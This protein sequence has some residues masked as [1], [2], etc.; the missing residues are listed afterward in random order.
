M[1]NSV[2]TTRRREA[3]VPPIAHRRDGIVR[4][5]EWI[6]RTEKD[7]NTCSSDGG[8]GEIE[9]LWGVAETLEIESLID[10]LLIKLRKQPRI[11]GDGRERLALV[12]PAR[13]D[14]GEAAVLGFKTMHRQHNLPLMIE[15]LRPSGRFPSRLHRRKD[16][17]EKKADDS[18][19][20]QNFHKREAASV[21][22]EKNAPTWDDV[23]T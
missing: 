10:R 3:E 13:A 1:D 14:V 8:V 17:S 16:Q 15:A 7:G 11:E 18:D 23:V 6:G 9:V 12:E 2:S 5:V 21:G 4:M 19:D 22:G 20:H